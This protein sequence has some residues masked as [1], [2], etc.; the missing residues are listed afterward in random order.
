MLVSIQKTLLENIRKTFI[1]LPL[2]AL[3]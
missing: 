1:A 3:Y 2:G